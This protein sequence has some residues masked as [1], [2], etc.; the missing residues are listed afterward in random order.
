MKAPTVL[1]IAG[2]DPSGGAAFRDI[3]TIFAEGAAT[4]GGSHRPYGANTL[5][6][7]DVMPVPTEFLY[8]QIGRGYTI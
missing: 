8:R 3:K 4:D 6:V 2:S 7:S 5:G 1:S